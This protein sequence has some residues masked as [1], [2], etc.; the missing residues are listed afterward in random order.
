MIKP[1]LI[2]VWPRDVFHLPFVKRIGR[3]R[4]LFDKVITIISAGSPR[5]DYVQDISGCIPN[6][7]VFEPDLIHLTA[8]GKDWRNVCVNLALEKSTSEYILFVEQDFIVEDGFFGKL[9][10][11]SEG[12][13]T[14]GFVDHNRLHPACILTKRESLNK[15]SKD[16]SAYP[17]ENDHF[18]IVTQ[19]LMAQGNWKTL[20]DLGL[21]EWYHLAS[22]TFN[23]G[24]EEQGMPVQYR[25]DE[26]KLYKLLSQLI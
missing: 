20:Q 7:I 8:G 25:P 13:D 2:N 14:V 19:Q 26:Y 12:L 9:F 11:L 22:L 16:F 18:A 24:L 21:T 4:N 6:S 10:K 5:H 23:I 17:P 3:D 15:T 1:D